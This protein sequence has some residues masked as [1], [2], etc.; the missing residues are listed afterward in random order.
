[1]KFR[2]LFVILLIIFSSLTAADLTI[3]YI[4]VGQGDSILVQVDG[5]NLLIDAGSYDV[6]D[7]VP[8][9]LRKVGIKKLDVI[10]ASHPHSDHI[11]GMLNVIKVFPPGLYVDNGES[12]TNPQYKPLMQY[13]IK[14]KIPY[15]DGRTGD[16]IPFA[17]GVI[18][19]ITHPTDLDADINENSLAL[20]LSYGS[21]KYFFPGDC[22]TCDA[23]AQVVKLAHHGSKGSVTDA[24][25][26]DSRPESVIISLGRDNEYHYPAPSSLR[27]LKKAGIT[28]HRTDL[29]GTIILH[30]DGS[31]YWFEDGT[32]NR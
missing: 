10:V 14:K 20:L 12:I 31:E 5:K 32:R 3:H 7:I 6:G 1:M 8:A 11:G 29:E 9:Y 27:E 15:F 30:A 23:D 24:L 22:E 13:L 25:L 19:S 18:L 26:S 21:Q 16:T 17:E 4:D 28:I 2:Y